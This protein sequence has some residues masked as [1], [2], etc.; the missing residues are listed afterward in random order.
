MH[1]EGPRRTPGRTASGKILCEKAFAIVI[2]PK[3]NGYQKSLVSMVYNFATKRLPAVLLK[4]K[5][6]WTNN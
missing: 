4:V 3:Y 5:L 1:S 2:H 6:F